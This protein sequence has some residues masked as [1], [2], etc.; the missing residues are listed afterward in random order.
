M[1]MGLVILKTL[2]TL[3]G[4]LFVYGAI[5]ALLGGT[6]RSPEKA[7]YGNYVGVSNIERSSRP[8]AFWFCTIAY[9]LVG[10]AILYCAWF[11]I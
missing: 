9:I 1:N 2:S 5:R 10:A 3:A 6:F 8:V 7:V 11:V 4:A